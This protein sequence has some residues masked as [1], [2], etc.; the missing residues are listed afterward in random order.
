[1]NNNY[2]EYLFNEISLDDLKKMIQN[3]IEMCEKNKREKKN[4]KLDDKIVKNLCDEY[5]NRL[6]EEYKENIKKE[7]KKVKVNKIK[8]EVKSNN[9]D[10]NKKYNNERTSQTLYFLDE[11]EITR[12][13]DLLKGIYAIANKSIE[14]AETNNVHM[15]SEISRMKYIQKSVDEINDILTPNEEDIYDINTKEQDWCNCNSNCNCEDCNFK[16]EENFIISPKRDISK[17]EEK[18]I[19]EFFKSFFI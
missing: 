9:K 6:K 14:H 18:E 7:A 2:F 16:D 1:M 17:K 10:V 15:S 4:T 13:Q 19:E 5:K 12:L 11:K 8:N 3:S